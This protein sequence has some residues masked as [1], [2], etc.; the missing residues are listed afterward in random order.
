MARMGAWMM[1]KALGSVQSITDGG[2]YSWDSVRYLNP[3]KYKGI[4]PSLHTLSDYQRLISHRSVMVNKLETEK[5]VPGGFD[6]LKSY[7]HGFAKEK[8]GCDE[9]EDLVLSHINNF[10][11]NYGESLPFAIEHKLENTGDK[12]S[13][14]GSGD[15]LILGTL[16]G[17]TFKSRGSRDQIDGRKHAK[18]YLL[19]ILA[20]ELPLESLFLNESGSLSQPYSV[21]KK[22]IG[23]SEYQKSPD[24]Y[25]PYLA[26][27][28]DEKI[29]HSPLRLNQNHFMAST[30]K[31]W[32]ARKDAH[33]KATRK[34]DKALTHDPS[35]CFGI[36]KHDAP[37]KRGTVYKLFP[38]LYTFLP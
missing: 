10:W 14:S 33:N 20:G 6:T 2:M 8:K 31:E 38:S 27:P 11:G 23:V 17:E 7:L 9:F 29:S 36:Q 12:A 1:A 24:S 28:G 35:H 3:Q 16:K 21:T 13:Y 4:L 25:D 30:E 37:T 22:L 32:L 26:L 19:K 34:H 15:Y 18:Y 5:L